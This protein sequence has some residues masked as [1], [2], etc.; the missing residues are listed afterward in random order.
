MK[1]LCV[2][3]G[4]GYLVADGKVYQWGFDTFKFKMNG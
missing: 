2:N 3:N 4:D 1:S